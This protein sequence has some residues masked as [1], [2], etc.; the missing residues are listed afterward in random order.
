M[1]LVRLD[2]VEL[3]SRAAP[4]T[5]ALRV[6]EINGRQDA[7]RLDDAQEDVW[8]AQC[9]ETA[10]RMRGLVYAPLMTHLCCTLFKS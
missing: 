9:C 7:L 3:P 1:I 2:H 8:S 6:L 10:L 4:G 5:V